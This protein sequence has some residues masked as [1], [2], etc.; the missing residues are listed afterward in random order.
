MKTKLLALLLLFSIISQA[1]ITKTEAFLT[2]TKVSFYPNQCGNTIPE[3]EGKLTFC[4]KI[5]NLGVVDRSYGLNDRGVERML[6]NHYNDDEFYVTR[7]GL[8][9]RNTDGT[10]ENIPNITIPTYNAQNQWTNIATIK[11]GLVLPDGKVILQATNANY[12]FNVYDR[13]LKTFTAVNFPTNR[14]PYLFAYD[15]SRDLT[16]IVA[17]GGGANG[18][19]LFAYDGTDVTFVQQFATVGN[20]SAT[21]NSSTLIYK[22]DNLYIGSIGGL[23]KVDISDYANANITEKEYNTTTTPSLPFDSVNDLQFDTNNDLWLTQS[24]ANSDGGIVKFNLVN[25]TYELYQ[26]ERENNPSLNAQIYRL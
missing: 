17:F 3:A 23:Y 15:T 7:K 6:V 5:D 8:S 26:L 22:D 19:Y 25:E 1:Q 10:W 16:W 2:G 12:G 20:I 14:F 13:M 21:A 18:R 24:Q 9:I 11:N 4:D